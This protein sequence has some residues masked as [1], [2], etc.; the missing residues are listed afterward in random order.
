MVVWRWWWWWWWCEGVDCKG[1]A[2][3][4]VKVRR[5]FV[6][7]VVVGVA[8]DM[9]VECTGWQFDVGRMEECKDDCSSTHSTL[10][11]LI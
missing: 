8:E 4:R 11:Y 7:F 10:L 5:M 1:V 3:A 2:V 9:F 6:A